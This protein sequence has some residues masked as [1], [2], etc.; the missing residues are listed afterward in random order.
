MKTKILCCLSVMFAVAFVLALPSCQRE[1]SEDFSDLYEAISVYEAMVSD[2]E[3]LEALEAEKTYV[4]IIPVNCGAEVFNSAA[5]LSEVMSK[6]VGY[7]VEVYYDCDIKPKSSNLEI[8]IGDTDRDKSQRYQKTL[9]TLDYGYEYND[10]AVT[11]G[12][13]SDLLVAKAVETFADDIV[14][15]KV[16]TA[17][18]NATKK[19]SVSA[20][21]EISEATL[22]SFPLSEYVIVYPK[23]NML[24]EKAIAE[25]L[26]AAIEEYA[27]YS[28]PVVSDYEVS[29]SSKHICIGDTSLTSS[30]ATS[31]AAFIAAVE[32]GT[33]ELIAQ[34]NYGLGLCVSRFMD[35]FK[36]SELDGVCNVKLEG[37]TRFDYENEPLRFYL[38]RDDYLFGSL[39]SYENASKGAS[40]SSLA[41]FDR[42]SSGVVTEMRRNLR[43][44]VSLEGNSFY[45]F[46]DLNLRCIES[47]SV[48]VD[49]G[50]IVTFVMENSKG[51]R[52][53]FV[54]GFNNNTQGEINSPELCA[55]LA[56][57]CEKYN[58]IP[59]LVAHELSDGEN[60]RFAGKFPGLEAIGTGK[61]IYFTRDRFELV[62]Y[63]V[64]EIAYPL[65]ADVIELR[66][67]FN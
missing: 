46:D 49:D 23:K 32:N 25:R 36:Y 52:F 9:R 2:R 29:E 26:K 38:V 35:I 65:C 21:Y 27:G 19:F 22:F 20:E 10:G 60:E 57:E 30:S 58:G 47:Q 66:F 7:R 12:G 53:A 4:I 42:L 18:I 50:E 13:H 55:A 6:R 16:L 41:V 14:S 3:R 1:S 63:T 62:S 44:L 37:I 61:G 24:R 59:L 48:I 51:E 45:C 31:S 5:L 33:V 43:F 67:C 64:S 11:V 54:C 34:D 56:A 17:Y 15:G 28:L 8:L 40:Q 39:D